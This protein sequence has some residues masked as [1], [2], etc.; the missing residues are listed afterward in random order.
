MECSTTMLKALLDVYSKVEAEF[1]LFA[2]GYD[3]FL[4]LWKNVAIQ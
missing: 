3:D 2:T 1:A 4:F